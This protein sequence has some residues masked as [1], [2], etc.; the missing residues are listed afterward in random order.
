MILNLQESMLWPNISNALKLW[1]LGVVFQ[2]RMDHLDCHFESL[3][4]EFKSVIPRM[5]KCPLYPSLSTT[6]RTLC[7]QRYFSH[8]LFS[9]NHAGKDWTL[10]S[11]FSPKHQRDPLH[12]AN[13]QV[14]K[15]NCHV[16]WGKSLGMPRQ[17]VSRQT[18]FSAFKRN[19]KA[20]ENGKK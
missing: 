7:K 11:R 19:Q 2:A 8:H 17:W 1:I 12:C 18:F 13:R 6:K 10:Y 9:D 20:N 3:V 5:T 15:D 4:A 16:P 14:G